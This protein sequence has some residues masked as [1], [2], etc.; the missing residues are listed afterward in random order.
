MSIESMFENRPPRS[1]DHTLLGLWFVSVGAK[2]SESVRAGTR[3][4]PAASAGLFVV[5]RV[6]KTRRPF[7]LDYE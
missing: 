5:F 6:G 4:R 1:E 3:C 2:N 7:I